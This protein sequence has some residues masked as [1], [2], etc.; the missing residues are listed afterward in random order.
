MEVLFNGDFETG[1][2]SQFDSVA[3]SGRTTHYVQNDTVR[4]GGKAARL[5]VEPHWLYEDNPG[6]RLGWMNKKNAAPEDEKNLPDAAFYSAWYY[7]PSYVETPWN[8]IMQWKGWSS[9]NTRSPIH[10]VRLFGEGGVMRLTL[11]NRVGEETGEY[12][13]SLPVAAT[14]ELTLPI[15]RWFQLVTYYIWSKEPTGRVATFVDGEQAWDIEG[16]RTDFSYPFHTYPRQW[17][18]N[19]YTAKMDL[20][21]YSIFIDDCVVWTE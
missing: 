19:N 6:V 2:F 12:D 10:A 20:K 3:V 9:A 5:T 17:A 16:I 21:K 8:N 14:S 13:Q 11:S 7:L 1:N 15:A 18:V 4:S